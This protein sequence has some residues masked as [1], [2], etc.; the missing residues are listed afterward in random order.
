MV[1]DNLNID[2]VGMEAAFIFLYFLSHF[3]I[4]SF[5]IIILLNLYIILYYFI[6]KIN[7]YLKLKLLF[8]IWI[9]D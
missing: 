8:E 1:V 3:I 6:N 5:L 4:F 7:Y 2:F 9:G